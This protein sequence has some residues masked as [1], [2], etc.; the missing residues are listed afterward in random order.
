MVSTVVSV[1]AQSFGQALLNGI[2][3]GVNNAVQMQRQQI[4]QQQQRQNQQ[5]YSNSLSDAYQQSKQ[6]LNNSTFS[7]SNTHATAPTNG[8]V[9]LNDGSVFSG[10]LLNG[11]PLD[12]VL[13]E[14]SGVKHHCSISNGAI[15]G[16][17]FTEWPDGSWYYGYWTN[18]RWNGEGSYYDGK[19]SY[20]DAVYSNGTQIS[21]REVST[22]K[23]SRDEF[24]AVQQQKAQIMMGAQNELGNSYY[25]NNSS[26]S[27]SRSSNSSNSCGVCHGTGKCNTCNGRGY[28]TSI[29][30]G[31]GTH[32][33]SS[34]NRT[35]RRH[36]CNGTGR[37]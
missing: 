3:R 2:A 9:K 16:W 4:Q 28:Y 11:Q 23:H 32:S 1:H 19:G 10:R 17:C 36:S 21:L 5:S 26:G 7:L 6:A 15:N 25:Q 24:N 8:T 12:G 27:S 35:G 30:I 34:C 14:P 18:G 22:P 37:R 29:G 31:S 20:Y 33:C 13:T